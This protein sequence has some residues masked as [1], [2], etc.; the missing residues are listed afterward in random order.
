LPFFLATL[1]AFFAAALRAV[2]VRDFFAAIFQY[3][4]FERGP[5]VT[6]TPRVCCKTYSAT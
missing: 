6:G 4:P 3:L 2:L 5:A 1:G